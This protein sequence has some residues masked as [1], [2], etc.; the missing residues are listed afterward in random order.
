MVGRMTSS[1]SRVTSLRKTSVVYSLRSMIPCTL[2]SP[3]LFASA[4]GTAVVHAR[5]ASPS[6]FLTSAS[7]MQRRKHAS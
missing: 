3:A 5:L 4:L 1:L 7:E 2:T 6:V